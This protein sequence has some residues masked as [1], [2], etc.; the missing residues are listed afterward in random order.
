MSLSPSFFMGSLSIES[1]VESRDFHSFEENAS[2]RTESLINV[3]R[4]K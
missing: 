4:A 3:T 1:K 2:G